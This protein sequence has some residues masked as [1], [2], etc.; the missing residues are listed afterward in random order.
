M[1]IAGR[2]AIAA[3]LQHDGRDV[4]G[5]G[6]GE[7]VRDEGPSVLSARRLLSHA[8]RIA[9]L[10]IAAGCT[11]ARPVAGPLDT[12]T[13]QL[14]ITFA[15]PRTVELQGTAAGSFFMSGV[16]GLRG[17]AREVR[18]DVLLLEVAWTR[19]TG[20]W[21]R[22]TRRAVA[23]LN[24]R[25]RSMLIS[26]HRISPIRTVLAVTALPAAVLLVFVILA[27]ATYEGGGS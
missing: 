27:L 18:D 3:P 25:D 14:E 11:V 6:G 17:Q 23:A 20:I 4:A 10:G 22:D 24:I 19:S 26:E 5:R 2:T 12:R 15:T 9:L 8:A 7:K 16:T 21:E 13:R 1:S